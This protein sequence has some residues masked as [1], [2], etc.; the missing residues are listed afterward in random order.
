MEVRARLACGMAQEHFLGTNCAMD[1]LKS[2]TFQKIL[3][4]ELSAIFEERVDVTDNDF[5]NE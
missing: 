5:A 3:I 1:L 2:A 4:G